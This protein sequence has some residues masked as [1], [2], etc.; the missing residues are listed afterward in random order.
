MRIITDPKEIAAL[1][2]DEYKAVV[3]FNTK[4]QTKVQAQG[5]QGDSCYEDPFMQVVDTM[6]QEI[7][8]NDIQ[9]LET[10]ESPTLEGE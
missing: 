1:N 9:E 4:G 8:P 5:F 10:E 6:A 2:L 7:V 3:T